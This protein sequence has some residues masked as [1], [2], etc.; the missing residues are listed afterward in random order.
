MIALEPHESSSTNLS[1][2]T[3]C[4]LPPERL[5]AMLGRQRG[6]AAAA[7]LRNVA[8]FLT[9]RQ[10]AGL[11]VA[12]LQAQYHGF[13]VGPSFV[14][15]GY[16]VEQLLDAAVRSISAFGK[17]DD[18][19]DEEEAKDAPRHTIKTAEFLKTLKRYVA[20]EDPELK[21]RFE[22]VLRPRADLPDLTVDYAYQRWMIQATSLPA[23]KNQ[24]V[25]ALRESQSKLYE[26]DL[27]RRHLDGNSVSAV[28]LINKDVLTD[29]AANAVQDQARAALD[30][31][32]RL[33]KSDGLEVMEVT[34]PQEA[35]QLVEALT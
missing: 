15:R 32:Q 19:V 11:P 9:Q 2:G 24:A 20:G 18:L 25:Y 8:D 17:A 22:K 13:K 35:A 7:V 1:A 6:T 26:I 34:S 12:E 33:A 3:Y 10:S 5:R 16:S 21:Q 27:I 4:V 29:N 30:R 31:L 23:T 14:G 28:L